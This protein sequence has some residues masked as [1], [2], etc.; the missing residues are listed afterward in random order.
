MQRW[1]WEKIQ[2]SSDAGRGVT[3]AQLR[4]VRVLQFGDFNSNVERSMKRA[5]KT[6]AD[7]G[8]VVLVS[9]KGG[10]LDPYR[11]TKPFSQTLR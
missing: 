2:I 3:F 5:L 7:R 9:G 1:I 11:Y 4:K 10:Q 6:L 8:D